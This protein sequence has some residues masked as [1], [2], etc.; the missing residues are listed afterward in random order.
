MLCTLSA[1][2]KKRDDIKNAETARKNP[3]IRNKFPKTTKI[4]VKTPEKKQKPKTSESDKKEREIQDQ[5]EAKLEAIK[6]KNKK[7]ARI[8]DIE[9]YYG[10]TG[11][12]RNR[13]DEEFY[14]SCCSDPEF[15]SYTQGEVNA[16]HVESQ[17]RNIFAAIVSDKNSG[18]I[19]EKDITCAGIDIIRD[20]TLALLGYTRRRFTKQLN[21]LRIQHNERTRAEYEQKEL[22]S[23]MVEFGTETVQDLI[24]CLLAY[25]GPGQKIF[26][27]C[28]RY[29]SNTSVC[30]TLLYVTLL[31]RRKIPITKTHVVSSL[32]FVDVVDHRNRRS[33]NDTRTFDRLSYDEQHDLMLC[34][35]NAWLFFHVNDWL[36]NSLHVEIPQLTTLIA[37]YSAN[38]YALP[39]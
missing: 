18:I 4:M 30:Q 11:S 22:Q 20:G 38:P 9:K 7:I 17:I 31:T 12:C 19:S 5:R 1:M 36:K 2:G 37:T 33:D 16:R 14:T 24:A 26:E 27:M 13:A 29:A 25:V 8:Q 10:T 35:Y 32:T 34:K 15:K 28:Y 6:E 21:A 39:V 23:L 3:V